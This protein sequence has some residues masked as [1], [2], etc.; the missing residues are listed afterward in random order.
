MYFDIDTERPT[1]SVTKISQF[2]NNVQLQCAVTGNPPPTVIWQRKNSKGQFVRLPN[3]TK[4]FTNQAVYII[5]VL[6]EADK[7]EYRC[8]ASNTQGQTE[9]NY[10]LY[11]GRLRC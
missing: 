9:G 11:S 10:T 4:G 2:G 1:V 5:E 7:A 8:V 3:A 6:N